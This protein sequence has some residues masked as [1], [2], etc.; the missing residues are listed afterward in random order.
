MRSPAA[1]LELLIRQAP[2]PRSVVQQ[3][4]D[5]L[6][7]VGVLAALFELDDRKPPAAVGAQEIDLAGRQLQMAGQGDQDTEAEVAGRK[8]LRMLGEGLVQRVLNIEGRF[9]RHAR[10]VVADEQDASLRSR[11]ARSRPT[12]PAHGHG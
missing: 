6:A 2:Q 10:A 7:R 4:R 1:L 5:H 8:Y 11:H 9:V 12:A 3:L